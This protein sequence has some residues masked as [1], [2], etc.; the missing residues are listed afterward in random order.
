M[1]QILEN[2]TKTVGLSKGFFLEIKLVRYLDWL[3]G[4]QKQFY[5]EIPFPKVSTYVWLS[6]A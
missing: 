6:E 1:L 3:S 2:K 4:F 5:E